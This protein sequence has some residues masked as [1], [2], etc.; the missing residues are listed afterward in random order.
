[1]KKIARISFLFSLIF[2]LSGCATAKL[3]GKGIPS[4]K[5]ECE[6]IHNSYYG[7]QWCGPKTISQDDPLKRVIIHDNMLYSLTSVFSLGLYVPQKIEWWTIGKVPPDYT[8]ELMKP[9]K[10]K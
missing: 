4:E 8:G 5:R 7:F 6:V 3:E 1:M 10:K 2:I 9:R